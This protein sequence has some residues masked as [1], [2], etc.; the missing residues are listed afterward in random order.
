MERAVRVHRLRPAGADSVR[1]V[2][3][4]VESAETVVKTPTAVYMCAEHQFVIEVTGGRVGVVTNSNY[5]RHG[6]WLGATDHD[7]HRTCGVRA[8]CHRCTEWCYPT[9]ELRCAH[10]RVEGAPTDYERGWR[11]G[12]AAATGEEQVAAI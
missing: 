8:W 10:C 6:N 7:E 2:P 9:V 11:D 5:D 12:W 3:P 1:L 4:R